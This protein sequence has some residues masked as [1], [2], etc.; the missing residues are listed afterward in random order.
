MNTCFI[1]VEN[2]VKIPF[3]IIPMLNFENFYEEIINFVNSDASVVLFFVFENKDEDELQFVAVLRQEDKL[4]AARSKAL[5]EYPSFCT[6]SLK[7]QLFEREI[8]EQYGIKPIG[9]PWFKSV[10]YHNNFVNAD[11]LFGNDYKNDI[12]G[13]YPFYKVEGEEIHEVAVGP[14]HAGIIEPGH[15][16]FNCAGEEI[17]NLEIVHGYQHR[18]IE[19]QLLNA[20]LKKFPFILES[21]AGDTTIAHATAFSEA[22]EGLTNTGIDD[23][24]KKI[25][26]LALELERLANHVGDLGALSGDVAFLPPAAYFG[27]IR[28]EFL[29][30]LLNISGNRF[31]KGLVRPSGVRFPVSDGQKHNFVS[32]INELEKEIISIAD[33]MFVQPGVLGRFE[34]TGIVKHNTAT[35]LGLVGVAGRAS[36]IDYD[37]RRSF[38]VS[39]WKDITL[40]NIIEHSGDVMGRAMV[41]YREIKQ[42][43]N[44]VKSLLDKLECSNPDKCGY[45][46]PVLEPSS[47]IVSMQEAWRGELAHC[48]ITDSKGAI[49]RYKIKDPSFHNWNGL[50]LAVRNEAIS[51][52]P[53]CN[54]SFNLSYCGFDL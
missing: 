19:K 29:N 20:D 26:A 46:Q 36:G 23:E 43:L 48:I 30:I 6:H 12:P 47:F 34:K 51:N 53:V 4:F 44:L 37:V 33:M 49:S 39:A 7:F 31:G 16:R 27:R 25:R 40:D 22:I 8:A 9:H 24:S 45:K 17:L 32:K 14:I 11:D 21:A 38:P 41:R 5:S 2:G 42:S 28:G 54:K 3:D 18:G 50:E 1:N 35:E 52:F 13:A 15:F 10:R